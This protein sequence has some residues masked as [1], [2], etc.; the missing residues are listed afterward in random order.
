MRRRDLVLLTCALT[1]ACGSAPEPVIALGWD[2]KRADHPLSRAECVQ[3]A[4]DFAPTAE[5]WR[6]RL[7]A[8]RA[9]L[10]H[11]GELPNP[12]LG[13]EWEDFGLSP[14]AVTALQTTYPI[15]LSLSELFLR[16]DRQ[17]EADH[18]LQASIAELL[19]ERRKLALS[20]CTAYDAIVAAHE[21][22]K[23]TSE[24]LD[25][26]DRALH[27]AQRRVEVGLDAPFTI[28]RAQAQVAAVHAQLAHEE[29]DVGGLEMA[30][31]FA[32][33][34]ERPVAL[35]LADGVLPDQGPPA[36]DAEALLAEATRTRPELVATA[37]HYAA[38]LD[39]AHL[40][41]SPLRFL[42]HVAAGP[43]T[44]GGHLFGVAS[45]EVELP[46]FDSGS[47][48]QAEKNA[49]L[50]A[51]AAEARATAHRVTEEV[52]TAATR[53]E[54]EAGYLREHAIPLAE[55]QARLREHAE[56][57]FEA[58]EIEF[59]ALLESMRSEI[60]ARRD[61][62]EAHKSLAEVSWPLAL[63]RW[64][65]DRAEGLP[66]ERTDPQRGR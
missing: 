25:V 12:T 39:R 51:A 22:R 26:A 65:R 63:D 48:E 10:D 21:G 3:L 50:L 13:V 44:N 40:A 29:I 64:L 41:A 36:E 27:A 9:R 23:L 62:L 6:A 54:Q 58:G 15:G 43:R 53:V 59:D 52:L 42:P 2:A 1:G 17:S 66:E 60:A 11:A 7:D 24:L 46:I 56:K 16:A 30:F 18:E 47:A 14:H 4:I 55:R 34:F 28:E 8:A 37:A 45:L 32:L 57:A 35:Q 20:V 33:G 31:A 61:L 19:V 38:A 5:A 49:D